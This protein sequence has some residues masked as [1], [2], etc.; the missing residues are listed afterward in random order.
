MNKFFN[1]AWKYFTGGAKNLGYQAFFEHLQS[2]EKILEL[3]NNLI[4]K[5]DTV[6]NKI[7]ELKQK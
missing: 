4:Y 5:I 6:I 7:D 3:K 1:Q 2:H